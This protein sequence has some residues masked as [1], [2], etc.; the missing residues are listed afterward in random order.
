MQIKCIAVDDEPPALELIEEYVS[1]FS[2]LKEH[3]K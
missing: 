3:T 1:R 2:E